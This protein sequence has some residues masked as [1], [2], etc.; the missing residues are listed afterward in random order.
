[1]KKCLPFLLITLFTGNVKQ[2]RTDTI[3]TTDDAFFVSFPANQKTVLSEQARVF[4]IHYIAGNR[5][6]LSEIEKRSS[7]PFAI[8]DSVFIHYG[9]PT[10]LK[11]LA[12]IESDLKTKAVS[13]VGAKGPW[14]LMTPTAQSLGLKVTAERDERIGYMTSTRAAA[15]YLKDLYAEFG[16]WLLVLAA[17]N[18]GPGPVHHAIRM[19]GSNNF[20]A[21]Q[22]YLPAESRMHVKRFLATE[23][24]FEGQ[25]RESAAA[26]YFQYL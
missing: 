18:G 15:L 8:I 21:L 7:I 20:W 2:D 23:Y 11:Y 17:Y 14:Q 25:G 1:M 10:Q 6:C 22:R 19:A 4:A 24:Y 13:R 5:E 12:V 16:D 9:L 3:N 26:S